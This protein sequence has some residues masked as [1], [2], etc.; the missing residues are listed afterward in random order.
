MRDIEKSTSILLADGRR[1]LINSRTI[2]SSGRGVA[3][4]QNKDN[5]ISEEKNLSFCF[6]LTKS[7]TQ[8][9]RSSN[10][11]DFLPLIEQA[12]IAWID[13]KVE[14]FERETVEAGTK[15]GFSELLIKQL[16]TRLG[17]SLIH[18]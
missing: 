12:S 17:L 6:T 4:L 8:S 14:D 9:K 18:I 7:G 13:L 1:I 15:I 10:I 11:E 16:L 2:T 3:G 5:D